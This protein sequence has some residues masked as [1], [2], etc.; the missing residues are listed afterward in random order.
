MVILELQ[1]A[2]GESGLARR[3]P[4]QSKEAKV[5]GRQQCWFE[6]SLSLLLTPSPPLIKALHLIQAEKGHDLSYAPWVRAVK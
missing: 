1:L 2:P 6:I 4:L 3:P 5:T